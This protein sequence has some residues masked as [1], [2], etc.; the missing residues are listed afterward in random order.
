[1]LVSSFFSSSVDGAA[2][3]S[4]CASRN[5]DTKNG[6]PSHNGK[7]VYDN[8]RRR[9]NDEKGEFLRS[10]SAPFNATTTLESFSFSNLSL[11]VLET[12]A[13]CKTCERLV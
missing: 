12:I 4:S 1:M 6:K 7:P 11:I 5:P 9:C 3:L 8:D 10:N 2:N 13:G